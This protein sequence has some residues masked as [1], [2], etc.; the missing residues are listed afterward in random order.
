MKFVTWSIVSMVFHRSRD[1]F[2]PIT[3]N[4]E[5]MIDYDVSVKMKKSCKTKA[6][7]SNTLAAILNEHAF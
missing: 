1:S 4:S 5:L 2:E 7:L 6:R 3:I